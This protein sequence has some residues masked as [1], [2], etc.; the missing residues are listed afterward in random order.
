MKHNSSKNSEQ[1]TLFTVAPTIKTV[2]DPYWDEI[3]DTVDEI[4][5]PLIDL[6]AA[7]ASSGQFLEKEFAPEQVEDIRWNPDHFG[8]ASHK[9]DE[10]GQLTIFYDS[11]NEPPDPD[12]YPN[13]HDYEA[14]WREWENKHQFAPEHCEKISPCL[15][16]R[17]QVNTDT[18]KVAPEQYQAPKLTTAQFAPEQNTHWVESY[19]VKRGGNKYWYY[20]Y[21]WMFGRKK[22]RLHLGSVTSAIAI[23]K[24]EAVESAIADG[25]HPEKIKKLIR[26]WGLGATS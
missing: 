23:R 22:S 11:S 13:L 16:V 19:W 8:N 14:A 17:A 12:D 10:G 20:R 7:P 4:L 15:I 1:L 9:I 18:Q 3:C 25:D 24:K 26:Q 5:Q 21:C 2:H 6:D